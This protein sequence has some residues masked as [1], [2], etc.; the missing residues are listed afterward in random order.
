MQDILRMEHVSKQYKGF[1]LEDVNLTLPSGCIMGFIGE[2]GAGKTTTIKLI[3]DLIKRDSGSIRIFGEECREMSRNVKEEIG[4]VM[5]HCCFS[6]ELAGKHVGK[7]MGGF[8]RNWDQ[9]LF[10][11]LLEKYRID[12]NKMV[13]Q[14]SRGMKMKLSMAAA[15]AHSPRLLILDECTGGMDPVAREALLEEFQNFIMDESHSIF[16]SSHIISD[17]EKIC[18]YITFIHK[19]RILFSEEKDRLL[20]THGILHCTKEQLE[21]LKREAVVGV[22]K[23]AFGAEALVKR[24]EIPAGWNTEPVNLEEIMLYYSREE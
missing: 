18:D 17:L 13:K 12:G 11:T 24:N 20:E 22:R 2:N 1:A 4:V 19:G 8:Y 6:E 3:L 9:D 21:E 5:D 23:G 15:L 7:I 16:I 14:Y 10:E